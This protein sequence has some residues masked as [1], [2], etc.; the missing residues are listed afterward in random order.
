[1]LRSIVTLALGVLLANSALADSA[2]VGRA[3]LLIQSDSHGYSA[4]S[5]TETAD[6]KIVGVGTG[7]LTLQRQ[8]GGVKGYA[9]GRFLNIVCNAT[10]CTDHGANELSITISSQ[11]GTT[12]LEGSM[13]YSFVNV[14]YSANS[15]SVSTNKASYELDRQASGSLSGNGAYSSFG[16]NPTFEATLTSSESLQG[17]SQDPAL[18]LA[19]LVNPFTGR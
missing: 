10:S 7:L 15:I 1:M 3:E 6:G 17:V 2:V 14:T 9:N 8:A 19:F 5:L 13:N 16:L 11:N 18:I 4:T 12:H